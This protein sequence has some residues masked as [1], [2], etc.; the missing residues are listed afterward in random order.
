MTAEE[1]RM[2][3]ARRRMTR[4]ELAA[5]LGVSADYVQKILRED[6]KAEGQRERISEFLANRPR[7][8]NDMRGIS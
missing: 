1:I 4:R 7:K 6:R 2:E 3:L 5:H 8:Y